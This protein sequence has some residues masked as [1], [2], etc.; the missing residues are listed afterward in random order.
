MAHRGRGGLVV[1]RYILH[2]IRHTGR[3]IIYNIIYLYHTNIILYYTEATNQFAVGVNP[4]MTGR[5]SP[6]PHPVTIRACTIYYYNTRIYDDDYIIKIVTYNQSRYLR[7]EVSNRSENL[8][9]YE[10]QSAIR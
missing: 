10:V 7:A 9:K 1:F 4:T 3:Y 5:I 6:P 2:I 8:Q